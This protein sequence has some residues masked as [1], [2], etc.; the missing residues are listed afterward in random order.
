MQFYTKFNIEFFIP[1]AGSIVILNDSVISTMGSS[2]TG[3]EDINSLKS[4]VF[5]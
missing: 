3:S 5:F 4:L 1:T 2:L